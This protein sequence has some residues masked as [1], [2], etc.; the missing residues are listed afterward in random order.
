[1][2]LLTNLVRILPGSSIEAERFESCADCSVDI[3]RIG[4]VTI[5]TSMPVIASTHH[6]CG[7]IISPSSESIL[8]PEQAAA[9][10][11]KSGPSGH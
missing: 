4:S 3:A 9:V 7:S 1:M 6:I 11:R 10:L 2:R 5:L 8:Q